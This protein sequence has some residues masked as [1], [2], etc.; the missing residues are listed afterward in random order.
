[1]VSTGGSNPLGQGSNPWGRTSTIMEAAKYVYDILHVGKSV[2]SVRTG[3]G[4]CL[5]GIQKTAMGYKFYR[6]TQN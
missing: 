3:I 1:M 6:K 4:K 5:N 2:E